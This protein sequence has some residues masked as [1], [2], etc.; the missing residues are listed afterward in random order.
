M[1]RSKRKIIWLIDDEESSICDLTEDAEDIDDIDICSIHEDDT[2]PTSQKQTEI[3]MINAGPI[4]NDANDLA[5]LNQAAPD[6]GALAVGA[7]PPPNFIAEKRSQ[8]LVHCC[9]TV[10]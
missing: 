8:P 10:V 4:V 7:N 1:S 9:E 6:P 3:Q 5:Y 2:F